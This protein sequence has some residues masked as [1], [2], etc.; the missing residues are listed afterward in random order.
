M[1]NLN[2]VSLLA[3]LFLSFSTIQEATA[4]ATTT[5]GTFTHQHDQTEYTVL[6]LHHQFENQIERV[7]VIVMESYDFD[8]LDPKARSFGNSHTELSSKIGDFTL[9]ADSVYY[10]DYL[11][12]R[13]EQLNMECP[14][15]SAIDHRTFFKEFSK[16]RYRK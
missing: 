5:R 7:N 4:E 2:F 8:T 11:N 14:K 3:I 16:A 12:K 1:S 15:T 10:F 9:K 13:F 6:Y